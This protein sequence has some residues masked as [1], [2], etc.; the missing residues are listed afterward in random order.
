MDG[1]KPVST[2]LGINFRLCRD[3]SPKLEEERDYM[4]KVYYASIVG[5]LKYASIVECGAQFYT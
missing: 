5:S 3:Q 1:S 2:P 4:N